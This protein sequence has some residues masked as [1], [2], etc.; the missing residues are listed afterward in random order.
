MGIDYS[1][2]SGNVITEDEIAKI[3][4]C[5]NLLTSLKLWAEDDLQELSDNIYFGG[6]YFSEKHD[7]VKINLITD[8][9]KA[10]QEEF[11]KHTE[12]TLTISWGT[13][14]PSGE[15]T[16]GYCWIVKG[17]YQLTPAG[18]KLKDVVEMQGW[19]VVL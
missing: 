19:V 7:A 14:K 15:D 12:L 4:D 2:H 16:V 13:P 6:S 11:K 17:M 10:L 8:A 18:E 1:A 5:S 3:G 9:Y